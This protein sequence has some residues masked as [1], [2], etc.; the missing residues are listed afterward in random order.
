MGEEFDEDDLITSLVN[1]LLKQYPSELRIILEAE[2]ESLHYG[3]EIE[4]PCLVQRMP[5]IIE[6]VLYC[7]DKLLP[8]FN[9]AVFE[10]QKIIQKENDNLQNHAPKILCHARLCNLPPLQECNRPTVSAIRCKDARKMIVI[11]GTVIRTGSVKM[12]EAERE[13]QCTRCKHRFRVFSDLEQ[14]SV[15]ELPKTCPSPQDGKKKPCK[16]QSFNYVEGS[17]VCRDYQEIKIQEIVQKLTVGSI[18]RSMMVVCHD[19]LVDKCQAGDDITIAGVVRQMWNPFVRDKRC[20]VELFIEANHIRVNNDTKSTLRIDE[21][22]KKEFEEFWIDHQDRPLEARNFIVSGICPQLYGLFMYKLSVAL[23]IIGGVRRIDSCGSKIRGENHLL[24]VGDPGTGKSQLLRYAAKLT[25]RSVLT[26]GI[27]TS[28]AGLTVAAVKD[29][30]GDWALEAGALVLAD[31]GICCI[32]E[33]GCVREHDRVTI[34]EA[35]EQQTLSVAKAGLVCK[36]NTR[37]TIFAVMNPKGAYDVQA[38]LSVNCAIA[39]PL[40]S[41]F[42]LIL[43]M[44]DS[45]NEEWDRKVSQHIMESQP[46]PNAVGVDLTQP[47]PWTQ[48]TQGISK[49]KKKPW[50]LEKMQAYIHYVKTS[51]TPQL[52]RFSEQ[53]LLRY[54][55]EQRQTDYRNAARTTIR[56]LESLIRLAQAHAKLMFRDTVF[57]QDA[58]AAIILVESSM[59]SSGVTDRPSALHM[60]FEENPDSL[61]K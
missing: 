20:E 24:I 9:E 32:D 41:R 14:N 13:Y 42:D 17:H 22:L 52:S 19:D 43:L 21:D 36:L 3:L 7:P 56:L 11:S 49:K 51:F 54:Y 6:A 53:I 48:V 37:T 50:P 2:D 38:D 28:S 8:V 16:S 1:F 59:E 58:I 12:L 44:L 39:S 29:K 57:P 45:Q 35:M 25:N 26:T 10:A 27:G 23:T 5:K 46:R 40:L 31:G 18:P 47:A 33:F 60:I 34:H 15:I 55:Q 61:F 30:G 4:V